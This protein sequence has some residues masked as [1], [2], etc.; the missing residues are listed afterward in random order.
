MSLIIFLDVAF[1]LWVIFGNG[2]AYLI[3][4]MDFFYPDIDEFH[5]KFFAWTLLLTAPIYYGLSG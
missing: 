4:F 5:V 3:K 1:C 2:A